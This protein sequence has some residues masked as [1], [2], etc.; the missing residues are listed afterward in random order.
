MKS[1][2]KPKGYE[3]ICKFVTTFHK[4]ITEEKNDPNYCRENT[5]SQLPYFFNDL[6]V[7]SV[8]PSVES[9]EDQQDSFYPAFA[10]KN[11]FFFGGWIF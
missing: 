1:K 11:L 10:C 7:K 4:E 3:Y 9:P 5:G 6:I 8:L 2:L